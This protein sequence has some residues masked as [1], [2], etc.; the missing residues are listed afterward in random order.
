MPRYGVT[1]T[2]TSLHASEKELED[3]AQRDSVW[4][5]AFD[6]TVVHFTKG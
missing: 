5:E 6:G 2:G 3:C 4:K 1:D